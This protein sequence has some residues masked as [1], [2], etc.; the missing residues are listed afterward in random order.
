MSLFI[1]NEHDVLCKL[2]KIAPREQEDYREKVRIKMLC[3]FRREVSLFLQKIKPNG[4][5][6]QS[7]GFQP[8]G[9]D[10]AASRP[11]V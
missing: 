9:E 6:V 5:L 3:L 1:R 11:L 2:V 7:A 4:L 10:S 8:I